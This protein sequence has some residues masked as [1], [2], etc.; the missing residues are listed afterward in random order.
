MADAK[1]D[2]LKK[3]LEKEYLMIRK[4]RWW[5][6]LGGA[7]M[8]LVATGLISYKA[9]VSALEDTSAKV[10]MRE[11]DAI[12]LSSEQELEY[13]KI[14]REK[15]NVLTLQ[16][17]SDISTSEELTKAIDKLEKTISVGNTWQKY[18]EN[19]KV[20]IESPEIY[21]YAILRNGGFRELHFSTWNGGYRVATE[22]YITG[23]QSSIDPK[24]RMGGSMWIWDTLDTL[25]DNGIYHFYYFST[26]DGFVAGSGN[27]PSKADEGGEGFV[28]RRPRA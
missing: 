5:S 1:K 16:M 22:P 12:R 14:N 20:V 28:Y 17:E 4:G 15:S 6:F 25:D 3:E 18:G 7:G 2:D 24:F 9:S 21:E 10:A 19:I 11:I 26:I 27:G 13:I 23:D 8:F